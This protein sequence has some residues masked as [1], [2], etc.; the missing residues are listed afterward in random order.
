MRY[1]LRTLLL[2][3]GFGPPMLAVV[4]WA[5]W[6]VPA[7]LVWFIAVLIPFAILEEF[8]RCRPRHPAD[9]D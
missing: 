5:R 6:L 3:A 1:R 2:I 7:M 4:W 9:T 8:R